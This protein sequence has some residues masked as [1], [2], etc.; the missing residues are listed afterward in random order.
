MLFHIVRAMVWWFLLLKKAYPFLVQIAYSLRQVLSNFVS[1]S[2]SGS[3]QKKLW[4]LRNLS[5]L[6]KDTSIS[7]KQ[8]HK[9]LVSDGYEDKDGSSLTCNK[10]LLSSLVYHQNNKRHKQC[11]QMDTVLNLYCK[12]L[13]TRNG[14]TID[15][16]TK[17][18]IPLRSSQPQV[19]WYGGG[20]GEEK[21]Y[22]RTVVEKKRLVYCII[23]D[24]GFC[25][26]ISSYW[27]VSL[28]G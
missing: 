21:K 3:Q 1:A 16:N 10:F 18:L 17:H 24:V 6:D 22:S 19:W 20:G 2:M 27:Y 4:I 5:W 9:E 14:S 15:Q 8:Y 12:I 28:G 26:L 25:T 13:L 23:C 11:I 7:T